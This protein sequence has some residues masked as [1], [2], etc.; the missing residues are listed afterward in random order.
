MGLSAIS[1]MDALHL[2]CLLASGFMRAGAAACMPQ[3]SLPPEA[4]S[5]ERAASRVLG[6]GWKDFQLGLR[7]SSR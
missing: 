1:E 6:G 7:M 3:F 5:V 4:D 2:F